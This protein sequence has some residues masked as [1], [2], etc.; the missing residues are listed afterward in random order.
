MKCPQCGGKTAVINTRDKGDFYRRRKCLDCGHRFST[1]EVRI[2]DL[3]RL[4][5]KANAGVAGRAKI[6]AV[7]GEAVIKLQEI[8][9]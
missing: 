5:K 4:R 3:D 8:D 7:I 1:H 9:R 6:K 2:E